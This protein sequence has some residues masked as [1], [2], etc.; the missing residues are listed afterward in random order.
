VNPL[1]PEGVDWPAAIIC[2]E[3]GEA[4]CEEHVPPD[5]PAEDARDHLTELGAAERFTRLHG[6]RIRYDYRRDRWLLWEGHRWRPDADAAVMRLAFAGAREWQREV[7]HA[8]TST[9]TKAAS[10]KFT[11]SLE[12]R[13]SLANMLALAKAIKPIAD[14][15]EDWDADPWLLGTPSGVVDLRTGIARPGRPRDRITMQTRAK[16]EPTAPCPRWEQF[17]GEVFDGQDELI[18]FLQRAIG[19]SLTGITTEQVLFMLYGTGANGKGTF[20]NTLKHALGDYAWN[21]P[22]ATVELH[23]RSAIPNDIAALV[24]RRF[25]IASETNDGTRMNEARVKALTGCDPMTARFLHSEFFEFEPVAKFWL[26]VNHRPIVRD[27]SY[28]FWRRLRLIPFKKRFTLDGTLA[29]QLEREAPGI[30]AWAVRGALA[31][32]ADGLAAP[33][34]VIAATDAYEA[35]SDPLRD[36]LDEA[37]DTSNPKA[38]EFSTPLFARYRAW[39]ERRGLTERERLSHNGFGRKM[40]ERFEEVHDRAGTL[41]TGVSLG[42]WPLPDAS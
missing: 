27:N 1:D 14:A 32:Q 21:M 28:G 3:C 23:E 8:K 10:L 33:A 6:H 41:Y 31:W 24:N 16:F 29:A 7:F 11:F 26:S 39:A 18:T 38:S 4:D 20:V 9:D 42:M 12:R 13:A 40:G 30:L 35:E 19:Y 15:G 25:V 22:F 37:C 34:V 5:S 2:P 17:L 36:F